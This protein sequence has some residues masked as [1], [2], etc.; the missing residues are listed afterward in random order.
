MPQQPTD[1]DH[2]RRTLEELGLDP[3]TEPSASTRTPGELPE[4]HPPPHTDESSHSR[5]ELPP[6]RGP[7]HREFAHP[8]EFNEEY[9]AE[10]KET[11]PSQEAAASLEPAAEPANSREGNEERGEQRKRRRRR[12]R[13]GKKDRTTPAVEGKETAAEPSHDEE[14]EQVERPTAKP[15]A[16]A[17][18]GQPSERKRRRRRHKTSEAG[19]IEEASSEQHENTQ[20]VKE[21]EEEEVPIEDMSTWSVPSWAEIIAALYRPD[22]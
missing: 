20:G 14:K 6:I 9:D 10:M 3:E 7:H 1:R 16:A 15:E 8:P 13:R 4:R 12:G 5:E 19:S 17:E 11:E 22:R 18:E 21:G 2:W